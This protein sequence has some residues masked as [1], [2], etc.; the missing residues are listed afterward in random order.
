MSLLPRDSWSDFG[1]LFDNAVPTFHPRWNH[2]QF[3]PNVDVMEKETAFEII[4]DLP[5][6]DKDNIS[7]SCEKGMLTISA[8]T[9]ESRK[10]TQQEKYIRKERYQGKMVRSFTLSNN[11]NT[12][13]I[14]AE[15]T[16]GVLVVVVPKIEPSAPTPREIE[17]S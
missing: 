12:S 5:G 13:D 8:V 15:F 9:I 7:V 3:S 14:Y 4:A 6:V 11:V 1:R 2:W 16:D 17:I 10:D